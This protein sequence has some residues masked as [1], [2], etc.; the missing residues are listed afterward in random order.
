MDEIEITLI[1]LMKDWDDMEEEIE[2]EHK[3]LPEWWL[4]ALGAKDAPRPVYDKSVDIYQKFKRFGPAVKA[5]DF[6]T[7]VELFT[8]AMIEGRI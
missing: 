4:V 3:L 6:D 1:E 2:R 7:A 8:L 5:K